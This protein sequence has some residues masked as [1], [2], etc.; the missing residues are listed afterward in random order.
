M[1]LL[2]S[3]QVPFA[4]WQCLGLGTWVRAKATPRLRVLIIGLR[5]TCTATSQFQVTRS[6]AK[7]TSLPLA[8]SGPSLAKGA[9]ACRQVVATTALRVYLCRW[10]AGGPSCIQHPWGPT[11]P[12][13][14]EPIPHKNK[15]GN[16]YKR[17]VDLKWNNV[18]CQLLARGKF[19]CL[20]YESL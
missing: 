20:F 19:S 16:K 9:R 3:H 13:H 8:A 12:S 1:D 18:M 11:S 6:D 17:S 14:R 15:C 4:G 2:R 7:I 5:A 10:W